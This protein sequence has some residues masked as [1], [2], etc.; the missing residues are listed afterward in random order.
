M[1]TIEEALKVG[2]PPIV[3]PP[4]GRCIYCGT[5]EGDLR[6]EHIIPFGLGG[7]LILPKASCR[8]CE[9]VTGKIEHHVLRHMMGHFRTKV[10][11][12]TRRP[13][14]RPTALP[15]TTS[16][17]GAP[18][19]TKVVP[20]TEYPT[21]ISMLRFLMPGLLVGR[22]RDGTSITFSA[23][24]GGL[25]SQIPPNTT[26]HSPW[27]RPDHF[28][29][30][31]AKI[32]HAYVIACHGI[33]IINQYV[34]V[35]PNLI[36]GDMIDDSLIGSDPALHQPQNSNKN[37]VHEL[38][39]IQTPDGLM[40]AQIRLFANLGAPNYFVVFGKNPIMA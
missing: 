37:A 15:L 9:K 28:C 31:L 26:V 34:P 38:R 35:L 1:G 16:K 21:V 3:Y 32:A 6:R 8:A 14:E 5:T 29:A 25:L 22:P 23:W 12:P 7:N 27:F 13:K 39:T 10:A 30:M 11:L 24:T 18:F 40:V 19:Q 2:S 17:P 20:T 36:F 4:V 33:E